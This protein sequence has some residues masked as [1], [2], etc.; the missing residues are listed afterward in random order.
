MIYS[1]KTIGRSFYTKEA[2]REFV[3]NPEKRGSRIIFVICFL[4]SL[5]YLLTLVPAFFAISSSVEQIM[6]EKQQE[7]LQSK[8]NLSEAW[9]HIKASVPGFEI[10]YREIY[11]PP[12]TALPFIISDPQNS[13]ILLHK[14][15]L[16]NR[17]SF[18]AEG[19][20]LKALIAAYGDASLIVTNDYVFNPQNKVIYDGNAQVAISLIEG[21]LMEQSDEKT[22]AVSQVQPD[23][24]NDTLLNTFYAFG[25]AVKIV[26]AIISTFFLC[27]VLFLIIWLISWVHAL[28][29]YYILQAITK[30][31]YTKIEHFKIAVITK[32]PL[33]AYSLVGGY[34]IGK[35][36]VSLDP[37]MGYSSYSIIFILSFVIY[38]AYYLW[39][40]RIAR[41]KAN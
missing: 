37:D 41:Q 5:I 8:E 11:L 32:L 35:L 7:E 13:N 10:K 6:E 34:A 20:D 17:V 36:G 1:L 19:A 28:I 33:T 21:S 9:K 18:R 40:M 39:V 26:I 15:V 25:V 2:Y 3:Q 12:E 23:I 22:P 38:I 4:I 24:K 30:D 27:A 14:V 31:T 29:G 16:D